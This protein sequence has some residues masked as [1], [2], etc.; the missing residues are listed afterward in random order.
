MHELRG[1]LPLS[2][3]LETTHVLRNLFAK[4]EFFVHELGD[5]WTDRDQCLVAYGVHWWIQGGHS[6]QIS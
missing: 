1:L 6:P 3:N 5:R 4:F 2:V